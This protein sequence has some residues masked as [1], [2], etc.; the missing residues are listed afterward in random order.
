[1]DV[2]PFDARQTKDFVTYKE[3]T[4]IRMSALRLSL[5]LPDPSKNFRDGG[6]FAVHE[7]ADAIGARG[8]PG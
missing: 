7:H 1:M 2:S 3:K 6:A 5:A 4:R 8:K